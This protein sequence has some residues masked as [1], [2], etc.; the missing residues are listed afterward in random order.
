[1][2]DARSRPSV[3][4]VA[5]HIVVSDGA[6]YGVVDGDIHVFGDGGV[7]YLLTQQPAS[8]GPLVGVD[9]AALEDLRA[10]RSSSHHLEVRWLRAEQLPV[11]ASLAA[12]FATDSAAAGWLVIHAV[13]EPESSPEPRDRGAWSAARDRAGTL[14]VVIGADNWPLSHIAWLLSNRILFRDAPARVLLTAASDARWPAIRASL[15]NIQAGSSSQRLGGLRSASQRKTIRQSKGDSDMPDAEIVQLATAA[16]TAIAS[17]MATDTW[18][19][20]R[21][22]LAR[23]FRR[24]DAAERAAIEAQLDRNNTQVERAGDATEMRRRMSESWRLELQTM[25]EESPELAQEL[26]AL[27]LSV[28]AALPGPQIQHTEQRVHVEGSGNVTPIVAHG[29]VIYHG[30]TPSAAE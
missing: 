7:I 27:I 29:N 13:H 26:Q 4:R 10:W 21:A 25:L 22:G 8:C 19:A 11:A 9:P 20:A 3:R 1:M 5:Q 6:A 24:R 23:I 18:R 2:S 12:L 16:G 15:A 28:E 30:V 14:L 17:A